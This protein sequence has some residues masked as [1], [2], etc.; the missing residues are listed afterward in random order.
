[1]VHVFL[2]RVRILEYELCDDFKRLLTPS[3]QKMIEV[4]NQKTGVFTPMAI[5]LHRKWVRMSNQHPHYV[6][7][8][9]GKNL[10]FEEA[11]SLGYVRLA[12]LPKL[13]DPRGPLI[14]IERESFGWH[15]VRGYGYVRSVDGTRMGFEEAWHAGFIR[16]NGNGTRITVW[17]DHLSLWIPAEEAVAKNVLLVTTNRDFKVCKVRRK[18]F[19]VSAIRPGGLQGQW[20]NPLEALTY[21]MFAW[22]EGNV[23]DTWLAQPRITRPTLSDAI[24]VPPTQ[25]FIPLSWKCFYEAWKEGWI[26]LTQEPNADMVS[27]TDFD[28]RRV[29][30]AFMNLV[31]NPFESVNRSLPPQSPLEHPRLGAGAKPALPPTTTRKTTKIKVNRKQSK[32]GR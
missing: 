26:R 15:S 4:A 19:R 22:Q 2:L 11:F 25:E 27:V 13:L 30:K 23:A 17:D 16:R 3:W 20:L 29:I 10:P 21:G 6:D 28:N 8:I 31:V 24:F 32:K 14:F 1:M 5:A 9:R 18:L 7:S 12:P